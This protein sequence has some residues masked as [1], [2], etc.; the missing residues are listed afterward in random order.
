MLAS[1]IIVLQGT[2]SKDYINLDEFDEVDYELR[3]VCYFLAIGHG[4]MLLAT[5][6]KNILKI[7]SP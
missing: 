5:G 3:N 2:S 4:I 1:G 7:D 6:A